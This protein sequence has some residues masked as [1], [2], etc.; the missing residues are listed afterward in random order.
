[1]GELATEYEG[2]VAF[3]VVPAEETARRAEEIERFGF[4]ALRH[5]LVGFTA[6][7]EPLVQMPGHAFGKQEIAAQVERLLAGG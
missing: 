6:G 5:G 4:T 1:V 2:R 7:G 3:E